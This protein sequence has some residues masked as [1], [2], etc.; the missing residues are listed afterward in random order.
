MVILVTVEKKEFFVKNERRRKNMGKNEND[1]EIEEA[2][3]E[4][5][6]ADETEYVEAA[7]GIDDMLQV[8]PPHVHGADEYMDDEDD[9][10][11]YRLKHEKLKE[12]MERGAPDIEKKTKTKEPAGLFFAI[13]RVAALF[14]IFLIFVPGMNPAKISVLV[15]KNLSLF[16]SAVS[17]PSL[18]GDVGRG[19]RAGWIEQSC[20]VVLYIGAIAAVLGI[21]AL[22]AGACM[23]LGNNKMKKL[24]F[25]F[26]LIGS[27]VHIIGLVVIFIAYQ[28]FTNADRPEKVGAELPSSLFLFGIL[29]I[30]VLVMTIL[31][32]FIVPKPEKGD[33]YEMET[34]FKLFLMFLPFAIL[35]FV[36]CYLPL[37]G[38]RF[39]FFDYQVGD[40]LSMDKWVGLKWFKH[41]FE[42]AATRRDLLHVMRN[43]LAMSGLGIIT[44]WLPLAFAVMLTEISNTKFRRFVQ[45]FTT[46]PNFISWILVYTIAIAI[47]A[48]EGF[49]NS[50]TGGSVNYL[51]G[52]NFTWLKMLAWGTWKGIGWSA[53]IYI[54][55]ISGID[56]QLYDAAHVD[57]ANR[58][59]RIWNVTLPGL[60]PTYMVML[61][62]SIAGM[63][64]NGLDQYLVFSN[65]S[66]LEHMQV[67]DLYV[68]KLGIEGGSY[69]LSVVIGMAK[70]IISVFLLFM[71]NNVS[72][73]VRKQSII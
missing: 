1:P 52:D 13:Q 28:Q 44:S 73:L 66:N 58:F 56:R 55:G 62:L 9:S 57:G 33:K 15:N 5:V 19:F 42:N 4:I 49:I 11:T 36:F 24:S 71:A 50:M 70:S 47:F 51:M 40:T 32:I 48:P 63:L 69:P 67:L 22:V 21:F 17:Y 60:M 20:F 31:A 27:V 46:I 26:S 45:T 54:A 72:K 8:E 68:Y 38:W 10:K 41:L 65:A 25:L 29:A 18:I 2:E 35:T 7:H 16:T 39:A 6:S 34:R 3:V 37:W 12:I 61:L 30:I 53:I 14:M 23:S 64:S 43:T 59:Q